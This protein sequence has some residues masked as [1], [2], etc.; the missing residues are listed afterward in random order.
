MEN[1]LN[2][3]I[4]LFYPK[5]CNVCG[6]SLVKNEECICSHCLIKLPKT[7]FYLDNQNPLTYLFLGK[8]KIEAVTAG[9][10]FKKGSKMQ[11]VIHLLKYK[12]VREVGFYLGY[13]IGLDQMENEIFQSVNILVPIPLHP[14]KIK[15]RGYNQSEIIATGIQ[16]A[17]QK[18]MDNHSLIRFIETETQTKKSMYNRWEN[19]N[20]IFRVIHPEIFI[21]KHILLID[22]VITTGSTLEAAANT[23]LQI[24]DTRVSIACLAC[25][26]L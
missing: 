1:L 26:T 16:K 14:N 3:F 12:G 24:S 6:N 25:A 2:D 23:L 22:D 9:F 8:V 21:G 5:Y 10:Y 4:S 20:N 13:L 17:L 7:N 15:K 11:H 19:T 18:P